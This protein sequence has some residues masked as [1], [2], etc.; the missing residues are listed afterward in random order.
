[1]IS[2]CKKEVLSLSPSFDSDPIHKDYEQKIKEFE[3]DHQEIKKSVDEAKSR[4]AEVDFSPKIAELIK[5]E[6][7]TQEKYLRL[8]E[9]EVA[10]LKVSDNLRKKRYSDEEL[11]QKDV[12]ADYEEYLLQQKSNPK[13]YVWRLRPGLVL[14]PKQE[15]TPKKEEEKKSSH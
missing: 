5:S 9:Q 4:I 12:D 1:M 3:K 6:I 8:I 14:P 11:T 15:S 2:G 7:Y 10:F 13:K